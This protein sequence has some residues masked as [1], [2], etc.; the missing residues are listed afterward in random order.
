MN[1]V[2]G[3]L[4]AFFEKTVKELNNHTLDMKE[5]QSHKVK[6]QEDLK[7]R[8]YEAKNKMMTIV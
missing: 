6:E 7:K 3:D 4:S 2:V 8:I 1:K 5:H